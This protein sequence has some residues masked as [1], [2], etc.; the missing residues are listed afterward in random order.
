MIFNF[1]GFFSG[2]NNSVSGKVKRESTG[3][4][5]YEISGQWSNEIF[6]KMA[7]GSSKNMFFDVKTA[8]IHPKIVEE[9]KDQEEMESRR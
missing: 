9:I 1:K 4:V 7:K 8:V 6:I 2:Q 3:E 5:L